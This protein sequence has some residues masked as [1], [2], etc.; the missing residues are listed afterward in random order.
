MPGRKITGMPSSLPFES[1]WSSTSIPFTYRW[2]KFVLSLME[3]PRECIGQA[4]STVGAEVPLRLMG[5][6]TTD[7]VWHMFPHDFSAAQQFEQM[8][9]PPWNGHSTKSDL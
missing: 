3:A 8:N 7:S 4:V 5:A 6:A 2:P 1:R 9:L